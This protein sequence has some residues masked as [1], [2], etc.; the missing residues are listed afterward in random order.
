M[1]RRIIKR[2]IDLL[3]SLVILIITSPILLVSI[4]SLFIAN[5][6]TPFFI[7]ERPGLNE[8]IFKIFKFKTM[9]D[10]KDKNGN[11]LSDSER[12]TR[13]GKFIRKTSIDE[14]PQLINVLKGDMSLIGP[15]P[16]LTEYLPLYNDFQRRRHDV[17]PGITGLAQVNG[18]NTISWQKKLKL[19]VYY[20][21]KV[22]FLLDLQIISETF[23][24][25][26]KRE[27]ISQVGHQTV[28]K[29]NG[30]N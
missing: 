9:N 5:G 25:V 29:F 22:S 14:L 4:F 21:N 20:V 11:L 2:I 28:E 1:Y 24:K 6:G 10:S 15:R 12:I 18:R 27:G 3:V 7:Q 13:I 19:D 16:L 26:I 8:R 17:K 30:N 23:K